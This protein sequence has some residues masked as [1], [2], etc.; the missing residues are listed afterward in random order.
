MTQNTFKA[1]VL[2]QDGKKTVATIQ[3]LTLDDL[4]EGDVLVA[5]EYSSLNYKDGLAVTGK[6]KIV[7]QF[8]MV[9]GVD[10]A[11]TVLESR[12][13]HYQAGDKVVLTGWSVGE[14]YWGGYAQ[15]ARLQSRW[16]VPLPTGMDTQTAM[17]IGTAGFTAMLCVMALE[18]AGVLPG[19]DKPVLV[20][21]ASGGVGSVAVALLA[22][23]GYT[24]HAV[25]GRPEAE[26]YLRELGAA[27]FV[28]REEMSQPPKP[29]EAQRWAGA[30]DTVGSTLLARVLA[31]VDYGGA[32]A[33]CGL[34]GGAD[35]PTTVMPFILRGV[36]LLGVDS[37]MCPFAR[38]QQAWERL[39]R[40][41]PDNAMQSIAHV[42]SLEE[43]PQLAADI[44]AGQV[45]GRVVV[46]PN[47]V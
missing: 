26:E 12:S 33:A 15:K 10:L 42:A 11:G 9:P 18:E 8:P 16:L 17:A 14:R 35:L 47:A 13:P 34:A 22:K 6:G 39:V 28:S 21:G 24:V 3:R 41:L 29:L 31:E 43:V 40:D 38:R 45:R 7:R 4:P 2:T 25:S 46:D 36:K 19:G 20:T 44:I 5:V 37:V 1:L 32:V 30:V 27:G 23:L